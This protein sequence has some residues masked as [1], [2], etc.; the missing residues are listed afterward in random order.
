VVRDAAGLITLLCEIEALEGRHG[1]SAPLVAARLVA[2]CALARTESRGGHFRADEIP[3]AAAKR[4]FVTF[5]EV[6]T[7]VSALRFAAE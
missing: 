3:A 4:T 1:R 7:P 2:A 6:D 5:S